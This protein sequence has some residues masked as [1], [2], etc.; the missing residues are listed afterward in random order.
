MIKNIHLLGNA[1]TFGFSSENILLDNKMKKKEKKIGGPPYVGEE[2][3][4]RKQ[5]SKSMHDF[6]AETRHQRHNAE[7]IF[8]IWSRGKPSAEKSG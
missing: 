4:D 5:S 1:W 2:H 6:S 7:F 3:N 8:L